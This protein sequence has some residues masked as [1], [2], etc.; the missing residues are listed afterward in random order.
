MTLPIAAVLLA[1][2]G[3]PVAAQ[4]AAPSVDG[5]DRRPPGAARDRHRLGLLRGARGVLVAP[6]VDGSPS[7]SILVEEGD[8]V[9]AGQVLARLNARCSTCS[10]PECAQIARAEAAIAQAKSQIARRPASRTLAQQQLDRTSS[11]SARDRP[12][13]TC[14]TSASPPPAPP[15]PASNRPPMPSPSPR[16]ISSSPAPSAAT[17]SCG[18][19]APRSRRRSAARSRAARP[20]RARS[21]PRP[22]TPLP[23]H[24]RE[25]GG[26]GGRRA[27]DD[28]RAY[29]ARPAGGGGSGRLHDPARRP[30]RLVAPEVRTTSRSAGF[31]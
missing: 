20:P 24:R 7:S 11:S 6:E 16:P 28:A 5:G 14:S 25:P 19:P 2:R 22:A 1:L 12:R 8:R 31:A 23:H 30:V 9:A 21:P 17:S 3:A 29:A 26:A 10:S 18:F 4:T 13:P 27:G 15:E